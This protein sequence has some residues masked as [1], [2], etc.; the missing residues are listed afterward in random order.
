MEWAHRVSYKIFVGE[1]P[2]GKEL[3]HLCRNP[4]CV[5]PR[6]MEAVSHRE[7]LRRSPSGAPAFHRSKTHCPQGHPYDKENT[8]VY[9]G[10]RYCRACGKKHKAAYAAKKRAE[11]ADLLRR[12]LGN[13]F[14]EETP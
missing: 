13:P 10:M 7:N 5:N 1:I 11:Q 2:K 12:L 6:H 8:V 3:D 14:E 4:A 9:R